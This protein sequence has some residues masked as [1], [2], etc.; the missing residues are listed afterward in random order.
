MIN[1]L[2]TCVWIV[3]HP[4][5]HNSKSP[6]FSVVMAGNGLGISSGMRSRPSKKIGFASLTIYFV[7][8][9]F[10]KEYTTELININLTLPM[11]SHTQTVD[12]HEA[13][14]ES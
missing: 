1:G 10:L 7:D 5:S 11:R 13:G 9:R 12:G 4:Y 8:V 2:Y 3:K 6:F 14:R